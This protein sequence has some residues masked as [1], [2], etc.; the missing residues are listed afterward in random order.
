[1][2][3]IYV[4][5]LLLIA[6]ALIYAAVLI[7]LRV[8][9][10]RLRPGREGRHPF[11][12][13]VVAARNE[14]RWIESCLDALVDQTYPADRYEIIVVND[15]SSDATADLI[16]HR[17]QTDAR[18][19]RID[20][21]TR[22]PGMAPKKWAIHR[23]IKE[24]KG[25]IVMMT[26]ADCLVGN[27]WIRTVISHFTDDVG[28]VAGFSPLDR[29]GS[30]SVFR[31]LISLD[32]LALAA[33]AAGS[34]GLGMPLT[35]SGRNL[36]YRKSLYH[37]VGGFESIGHFVSGDDDLFLHRV[38]EQ[39]SWKIRYAIETAAIV[40]SAPPDT[41]VRFFHQRLR[42]ASKG[43]HYGTSFTLG[44]I[45]VYSFNLMLLLSLFF[46]HLRTLFGI[47]LAIKTVSEYFLIAKGASLWKRQADLRVF[48][49]AVLLHPLYVVV[50]GGLGQWIRFRW[51]GEA[52]A[53]RGNPSKSRSE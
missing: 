20:I 31:H 50:L 25:E 14:A 12:T 32:A 19:R 21:Q 10:T 52:Y 45:A 24:S 8:G 33:V 6:L 15:R 17:I 27:D 28:L 34:F 41:A 16:E 1:M 47:V 36:A 38:R 48:P 40:P 37:E 18:I 7:R 53:P 23:G 11:V 9:L 13:V 2:E 42:H 35:C 39:T 51:K 49:L 4:Y 44:L 22:E 3:I 5:A 26:D 46:V 30:D 43:R 29:S